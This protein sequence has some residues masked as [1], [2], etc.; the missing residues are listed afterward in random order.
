MSL[1]SSTFSIVWD[2]F[3]VKIWLSN[4][5]Q[6]ENYFSANTI[7]LKVCQQD[8]INQHLCPFNKIQTFYNQIV[9][10]P[11]SIDWE[12]CWC[13]RDRDDFNLVT[14]SRCW[15]QINDLYD[16]FWMPDGNLKIWSMLITQMTKIVT[17]VFKLSP[18]RFVSINC[19]ILN[20]LLAI[21]EIVGDESWP[22][23]SWALFMLVNLWFLWP[24][25]I[26]TNGD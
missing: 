25:F 3:L 10:C 14:N 7:W 24:I 4:Y 9:L 16:I 23:D 8:V 2:L 5:S 22:T 17:N 13:H 18:V 1:Y 26:A 21:I 20:P 11:K 12:R 6:V 19:D 15:W